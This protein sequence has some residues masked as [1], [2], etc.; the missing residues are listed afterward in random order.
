MYAD[1][2]EENG[3][4]PHCAGCG[5]MLRPDVVWFG[6]SLPRSALEAAVEA[7]RASQVFLS[8][9]T[10]GLVQPAAALPFAARNKGAVVVEINLEPTPLTEKADYFLQGK[11]GEV[12]P[13]LMQAAW[14][15]TSR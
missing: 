10:S 15:V 6:E 5:G 7:A 12:L 13:A 11:S 1:A 8:I 9:G 2:W 4:V 3:D 14:G